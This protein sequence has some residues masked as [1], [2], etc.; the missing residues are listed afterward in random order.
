MI[1]ETGVI[2]E[3][4]AQYAWV[5]SASSSSCSHCSA[6][7]GC[8]T[9]S[10]QQWFKRKPNRLRVANNQDVHPGER[11][12]IGIPEQALVRGSFMIYMLP[13]LALIVGALLGSQINQSLGWAYRDGLSILFA[14]AALLASIAWLKR[15]MLNA[16]KDSLYQPV[17]LRRSL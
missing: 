6:R 4:D 16:S 1:E 8:G 10:L 15:Y 5:E 9:A 13:L 12:V 2:V 3:V 11:V 14:L 17:I 7:Q